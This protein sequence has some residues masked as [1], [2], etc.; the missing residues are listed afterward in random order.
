[1]TDST[2]LDPDVLLSGP[3][4]LTPELGT[5]NAELSE[6][7]MRK[8]ERG[9]QDE[10]A[11]A[12]SSSLAL[13]TPH[14][15]F[16]IS[17]CIER[18]NAI[19][20]EGQVVQEVVLKAGRQRVWLEFL[21]GREL[22]FLKNTL[23]HGEY[24][25]LFNIRGRGKNRTLSEF[26][27]FGVRFNFSEDKGLRARNFYEAACGLLLN[28]QLE[29]YAQLSDPS[30]PLELIEGACEQVLAHLP[31]HSV[32]DCLV[33]LGAIPENKLEQFGTNNPLGNNE[34]TKLRAA[35]SLEQDIQARH[36]IARKRL[37]G[38]TQVD[39]VGEGS[40]GWL[41]KQQL[42]TKARELED[43]P[44]SDLF[45]LLDTYLK[46]FMELVEALAARR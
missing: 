38:T 1:M 22:T 23:N 10:D 28:Q 25:D 4:A 36:D 5:R 20:A 11:S 35:K 9:M 31:G 32:R 30:Q 18:V 26:A 33:R 21:L 7:G 40:L 17:S 24:T 14:S 45:M 42:D 46:P 6:C 43:L 29:N 16:S 13:A 39:C 15:A 19:Y 2:D 37:W 34:G 3:R 44:K 12:S 27:A 8:A 41:L